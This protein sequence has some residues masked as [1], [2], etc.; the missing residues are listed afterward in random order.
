MPV[1]GVA[2]FALPGTTLI[3]WPWTLTALTARAIGAWLL[4]IGIGV[5]HG[6][7]ED[8]LARI[9]P[10]GGG[11]TAFAILELLALAR[12][13][14]D[15]HWDAVGAWVYLLFLA[16]LLPAGLYAW[17]GPRVFRGRARHSSS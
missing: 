4:G 12:Y 17:F 16:S 10:L 6:V 8:D 11:L 2:L 14:A 15:M 5:F 1:I 3:S 7:R 13:P 9:R